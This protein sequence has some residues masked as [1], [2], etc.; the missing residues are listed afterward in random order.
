MPRYIAI[1]DIHGELEK[2]ESVLSKIDIR[3]DDIFVFMGDYIDRGA[4]S[5]EVVDRVIQQSETNKCIYLIGSHEYALLHAKQDEYYNYLF[6]NYGGPATVKSYGGHFDN[7]LKTHGDFYRNLKFYHLTE[8]Y[9]F[10]HAGINPR[11]SLEEQD[12]TDFV[13][14]RSA[15]YNNKHYLPQKII[16]GHTEFDSPLI[17][18]D[19]ICID[20]GCG[21]YKNAKLCGLILDNGRE[22]FVYSD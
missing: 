22:E 16:F 7:I 5:K 6:W 15:F 12:E 11:Y 1:T 9:L 3:P 4:K 13:Y 14:I 8:D 21:K 2:L 20:L 17:Q 18:E 19:K 10:V